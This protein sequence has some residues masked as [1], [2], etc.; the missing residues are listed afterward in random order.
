[1]A[2]QIGGWPPSLSG[3]RH[4][5]GRRGVLQVGMGSGCVV[6]LEE[7]PLN[8]VGRQPVSVVVEGHILKLYTAPQPLDES[9]VDPPTAGC[10]R[11]SD[12]VQGLWV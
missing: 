10:L 6:A 12:T 8:S 11:F 4:P 7:Q 3:L 1:M 5:I 2:S 9:I